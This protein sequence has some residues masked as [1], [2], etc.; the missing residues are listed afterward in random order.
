[1]VDCHGRLNSA[2]ARRLCE[3]LVDLDLLFIEEPMPPENLVQQS[4]LCFLLPHVLKFLSEA[5]RL[6]LHLSE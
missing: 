4:L 3:A 5:E 6:T 1:M 2:S